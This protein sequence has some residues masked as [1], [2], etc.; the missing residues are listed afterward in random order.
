[1]RVGSTGAGAALEQAT[2]AM[3]MINID[4]TADFIFPLPAHLRCASWLISFFIVRARDEVEHEVE[5]NRPAT[6]LPLGS[7]GSNQVYRMVKKIGLD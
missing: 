1:L 7:V 4:N 2:K 3:P 5:S 6:N